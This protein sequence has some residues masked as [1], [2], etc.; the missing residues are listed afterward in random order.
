M[1]VSPA[2][3][4]GNAVKKKRSVPEGQDDCVRAAVLR[5]SACVLRSWLYRNQGLRLE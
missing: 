5:F 4:A 3:S 1:R 2:R